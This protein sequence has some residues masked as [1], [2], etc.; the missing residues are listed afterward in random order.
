MSTEDDVEERESGRV[1]GV[2]PRKGV[3]RFA[4]IACPLAAW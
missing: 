4:E 1:Q 2:G 3:D